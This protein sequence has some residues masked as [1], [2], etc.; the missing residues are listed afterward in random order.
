M[1]INN[2]L[3]LVEILTEYEIECVY[4][5]L[6]GN[7]GIREIAPDSIFPILVSFPGG[8]GLCLEKR[9]Q[10][11]KHRGS[12]VYAI[13]FERTL[14]KASIRPCRGMGRMGQGSERKTVEGK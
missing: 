9:R 3:N 6:W 10:S 5:P 4:S 2:R 12:E 11:G 14:P 1:E 8:S 7:C 13:S